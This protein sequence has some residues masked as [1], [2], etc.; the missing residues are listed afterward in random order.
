MVVIC[1]RVLFLTLLLL[2][3]ISCTKQSNISSS[4]YALIENVAEDG[5]WTVTE[6]NSYKWLVMSSKDYKLEVL[7]LDKCDEQVQKNIYNKL[8][9]DLGQPFADKETHRKGYEPTCYNNAIFSMPNDREIEDR[10]QVYWWQDENFVV[11]LYTAHGHE[12]VGME[13]TAVVSIFSIGAIKELCKQ[14][15]EQELPEKVT[16]DILWVLDLQQKNP[17]KDSADI[18]SVYFR[19]DTIINNFEVSG[20]LYPSYT[21]EYGWDSHENGVCL[22]F[23]NLKNGKEYVWTDWDCKCSCFKNYFISKNVSNIVSDKRFNGFKNGDTYIFHYDTTTAKYANNDLLP[24]AEY[25][26]YDVDFDGEDELILGY[27]F[28][29][30]HGSPSFEIYE[31]TDSGLAM[32]SVIDEDGY[33]FLDTSTKFD[34]KNK[35]I[36]NTIHDGAYAWGEYVYQADRKGDLYRLYYAS[37]VSDFEHNIVSADT[38]FFR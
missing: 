30:P 9:E 1:H 29:G 8:V 12:E 36:V 35:T 3:A 2:Y 18:V 15:T 13:P 5:D 22:F 28:G 10:E 14:D 38:T 37:F 34:S 19:F 31:I 4:Y 17:L 26:F 32:K 23:H 16:A 27:Y 7:I 24:Y 20:V 33:F 25:Q 11:R 6:W 21:K